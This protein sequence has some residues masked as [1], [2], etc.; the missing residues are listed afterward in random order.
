MGH[1]WKNIS[2]MW[3]MVGR[4]YHW[5]GSWLGEH[6]TDVGHGL[7]HGWE[8]ISL[9]WVMFG[10]WLGEHITDVG[11]VWE[12]ISLMGVMVGKVSISK[13]FIYKEHLC[14]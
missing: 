12:N 6:I 4:T 14:I 9:M 5:C 10:S 1:G 3:V 7:G 8:N 11:H 13:V 2:L